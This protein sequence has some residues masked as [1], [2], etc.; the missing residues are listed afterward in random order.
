MLWN[1][2]EK[3]EKTGEFHRKVAKYAKILYSLFSAE[4]RNYSGIKG[5]KTKRYNFIKHI[6]FR[7]FMDALKV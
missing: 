3:K 5:R 4:P 6:I 7:T 1:I 2:L